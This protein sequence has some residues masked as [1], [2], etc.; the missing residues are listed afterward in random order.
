MLKRGLISSHIDIFQLGY[1]P[2]VDASAGTHDRGGCTDVGQFGHAQIAV[3][4]EWGWTMQDRSPYFSYD[5]GHGWPYKCPHLAP[6][7]KLQERAWDDRRNGLVNNQHVVGQWPVKPWN[8]AFKENVVSL[9]GDIKVEI[10]N[11]VAAELTGNKKYLQAV[12]DAMANN[13]VVPNWLD[14][15]P[16]NPTMRVKSA[17]AEI[18][19]AT[20][21]TV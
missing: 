20:K 18:G 4:R 6:A 7:A 3:W 16:V 17:L 19:K 15:A 9:L 8:I 13:D 10:A 12:A 1:H 14:T 2:G 5:H 21:P 11:A